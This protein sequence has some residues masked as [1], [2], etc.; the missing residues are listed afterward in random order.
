VSSP[1]LPLNTAAIRAADNDL[2]ASH[3]GDPRLFDEDGNRIPLDPDD[4]D[5]GDLRTEWMNSYQKHGGE[6]KSDA[7]PNGKSSD[8]AADPVSSCPVPPQDGELVISVIDNNNNPVEGATVS[9]NMLSQKTDAEG[10]ADF[11]IVDPGT[12]TISASK[13]KYTPWGVFD[14]TV[15]VHAGETATAQLGLT[16]C[17]V[18]QLNGK[19]MLI[20]RADEDLTPPIQAVPIPGSDGPIATLDFGQDTTHGTGGT[21]PSGVISVG[22]DEATLKQKMSKL[23]DIFAADDTSGKARREFNEFQRRHRSLELYS[24][25]QLDRAIDGSAT[26]AKYPDRALNAPDTD[27]FKSDRNRIHQALAA[28]GWD[29]NSVTPCT[30]WIPVFDDGGA[31]GK[32]KMARLLGRGEFGNGLFVM[33]DTVTHVLVFVDDYAYDKCQQQYTISLTFEIYDTFGLDDADVQKFGTGSSYWKKAKPFQGAAGGGDPFVEAAAA[34]AQVVIDAAEGITAW[35]QLQHQFDYA[36]L[37]TK[38]TV[39]RKFTVSTAGG[40]NAAAP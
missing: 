1:T 9:A 36:P 7:P 27:A 31:L 35:W 8:K 40:A 30:L 26:F 19:A 32:G 10:V 12:Y 39:K 2:Y 5:E 4:P 34:E 29:V 11:G 23:I 15:T 14:D 38:A 25:P 6:I 13:D 37:I 20:A 16:P 33:I 18:F 28:A 22:S 3:P 24:D 17:V 21:L